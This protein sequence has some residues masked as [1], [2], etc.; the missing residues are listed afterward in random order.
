MVRRKALISTGILIFAAA[1]S[2]GGLGLYLVISTSDESETQAAKKPSSRSFDNEYDD[3]FGQILPRDAIRPIYEP[4]FVAQGVAKLDPDEL[5][6]GVAINGESK[7]YP[8][9]PL[10]F[11][12][13]VNDV[14]G[15]VPVMVSW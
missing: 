7:A 13:M 3:A 8:V 6:I 1:I 5:V 11:R 14:V 2:A 15:G 9:A 12:E 10:N 4:R